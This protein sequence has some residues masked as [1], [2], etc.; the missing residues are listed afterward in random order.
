[1][2]LLCLRICANINVPRLL[3]YGEMQSDSEIVKIG[4]ERGNEKKRRKREVRR[5]KNKIK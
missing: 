5:E 3:N 1:M 4:R 2:N